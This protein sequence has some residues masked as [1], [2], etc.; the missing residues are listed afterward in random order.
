MKRT[1]SLIAAAALSLGLVAGLTAQVAGPGG[2]AG[3]RLERK[4]AKPGERLMVMMSKLNLTEAQKAEMKKLGEAMRARL[5]SQRESL[6]DPEARK[7]AVKKAVMEFREGMQKIL[8]EPQ[9]QE[10]RRL[11]REAR[12]K[13]G[14]GRRQTPPPVR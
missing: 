12:E 3:K 2:N 7:A 11:M 1:I 5:Q 13:R 6:K 10:L 9:K 4:V 8:T 14:E